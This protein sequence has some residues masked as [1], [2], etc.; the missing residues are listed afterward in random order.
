MPSCL[1]DGFSCYF[2]NKIELLTQSCNTDLSKSYNTVC[3]RPKSYNMVCLRPESCNTLRGA[4]LSVTPNL[5]CDTPLTKGRKVS[6]CQGLFPTPDVP[7][8]N[9]QGTQTASQFL[10]SDCCHICYLYQQKEMTSEDCG[11]PTHKK[12]RGSHYTSPAYL[13]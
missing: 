3:S 5:C 2:L 9:H 8:R 6:L 4:L 11:V 12:F 7:T 10:L 13:L 1:K